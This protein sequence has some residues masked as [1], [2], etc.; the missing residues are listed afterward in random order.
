MN[1]LAYE[2]VW[3]LFRLVDQAKPFS[4]AN[5]LS[6]TWRIGTDQGDVQMTYEVRSNTTTHPLERGLLRFRC[7]AQ[8]AGG[9]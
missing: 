2:G 4:E 9:K 6:L 8:V 3:G 5:K 1:D 7:P